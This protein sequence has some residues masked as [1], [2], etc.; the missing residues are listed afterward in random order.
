MQSVI[1]YKSNVAK[2]LLLH[3]PKHSYPFEKVPRAWYCPFLVAI[4]AWTRPGWPPVF[5]IVV[6]LDSSAF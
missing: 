2:D 3:A 6:G 1:E 4:A 5:Y